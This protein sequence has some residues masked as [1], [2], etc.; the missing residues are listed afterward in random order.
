VPNK[1]FKPALC[2]D[3]RNLRRRRT[4][5]LRHSASCEKL[6]ERQDIPFLLL[7]LLGYNFNGDPEAPYIQVARH[8]AAYQAIHQLRV[9]L[10][11][12][13]QRRLL[14]ETN[15]GATRKAFHKID[16]R[17]MLLQARNAVSAHR[18]SV[19]KVLEQTVSLSTNNGNLVSKFQSRPL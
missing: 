18:H 3:Q 15:A 7:S 6:L 8:W 1:T 16:Q 9:P 14:H 10:H 19:P 2:V 13:A 11:S 4:F 5:G 17:S 12:R